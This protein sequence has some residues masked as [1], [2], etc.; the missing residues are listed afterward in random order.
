MKTIATALVLAASASMSACPKNPVTPDA[1]AD[2]AAPTLDASADGGFPLMPDGD[3]A[4]ADDPTEGAARYPMCVRACA[5]LAANDCPEAKKPTGGKT[6]YR[7][8]ADGEQN[9][10]SLKPACVAGGVGVAGIRA[11]GTVRCVK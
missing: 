10:L 5:N 11:C 2:A 3:A 4:P 8:C 1:S 7:V 9:G 6:C